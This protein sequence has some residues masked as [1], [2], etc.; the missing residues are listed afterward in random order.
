MLK[1]PVLRRRLNEV[2]DGT[3]LSED[4]RV[5]QTR[6]AAPT[7]NARSPSQLPPLKV[8]CTCNRRHLVCCWYH[9]K[10]DATSLQNHTQCALMF[11]VNL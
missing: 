4:G 9:L 2:S 6:A 1:S 8:D 7:G 5:L 3:D 10:L 11:G